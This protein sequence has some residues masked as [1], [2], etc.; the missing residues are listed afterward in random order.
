MTD[1]ET[2]SMSADDGSETSDVNEQVEAE[3]VE[4]TTPFDRVRTVM[5]STYK[6][7]SVNEIA[8]RARTTPTL[9]RKQLQRLAD[10]GFVEEATN[11]DQSA[12]IYRRSAESVA[13]E[14]ARRILSEVDPAT[15]EERITEIQEDIRSYQKRFDAT[16]PEVAVEANDDLSREALQEWRT[17]RRNL[18]LAKVA[19]ALSEATGVLRPDAS[20]QLEAA[21]AGREDWANS[22]P[23]DAGESLFGGD[24]IDE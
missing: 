9:A 24:F 11:P 14:Q 7:Q 12:T 10:V 22:T 4:E 23:I 15:L 20:T 5:R 8:D 19:L 16:S 13:L 1:E 17:T 21:T 6:A 18:E 2:D 3:W